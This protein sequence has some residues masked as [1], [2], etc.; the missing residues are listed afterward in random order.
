MAASGGNETN[1]LTKNEGGLGMT[2]LE[3]QPPVALA[4]MPV[5]AEIDTT[6]KWMVHK[7]IEGLSPLVG[8]TH[9]DLF[10][11][12]AAE[13]NKAVDAR[14]ATAVNNTTC[15]GDCFGPCGVG[16]AGKCVLAEILAAPVP[17]VVNP[18][19]TPVPRAQATLH[20]GRLG[21]AAR[22]G[23]EVSAGMVVGVVAG[24]KAGRPVVG[25]LGAGAV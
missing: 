2:P 22:R 4:T 18:Y 25:A 7:F 21:G 17:T 8:L 24:P 13:A 1:I 5:T 12:V 6:H 10:T 15:V 14:T 9:G 19:Q 16:R 11:S 3:S 23:V 20:G